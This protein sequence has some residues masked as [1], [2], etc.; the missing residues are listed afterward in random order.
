MKHTTLRTRYVYRR[1][2][3][4]NGSCFGLECAMAVSFLQAVSLYCA[5]VQLQ[6]TLT[7][8]GEIVCQPVRQR[9][10]SS[11][12]ESYT[13]KRHLFDDTALLHGM[14]P[15]PKP[16][17]WSPRPPNRPKPNQMTINPA[18]NQK[19]FFFEYIAVWHVWLGWLRHEPA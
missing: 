4:R 13:P 1:E 17:P 3:I 18:C 10:G 12:T 16:M 6:G 2:K 5:Y 15:R 8:A 7:S 14:R 11:I 9:P 19:R